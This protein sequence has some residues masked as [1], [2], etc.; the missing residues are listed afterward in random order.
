MTVTPVY[1]ASSI[2]TWLE[3]FGVEDL[4][5]PL[6]SLDLNSNEHH[7]MNLMNTEPGS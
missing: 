7:G 2:K 4:K 5:W 6:Q 3:E 1:K